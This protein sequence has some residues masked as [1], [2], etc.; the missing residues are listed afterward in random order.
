MLLIPFILLLLGFLNNLLR[1][2][3]VFRFPDRIILSGSRW[4]QW[5][6]QYI[7]RLLRIVFLI[8]L[9]GLLGYVLLC[10]LPIKEE[11]LCGLSGGTAVHE[12]DSEFMP[13]A[14]VVR[15][16][17]VFEVLRVFQKLT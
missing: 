16:L 5:R 9:F 13:Q 11:S 17:I 1:R 12:E 4:G 3:R 8:P 14:F 10:E 7:Q 15:S 6:H 2:F